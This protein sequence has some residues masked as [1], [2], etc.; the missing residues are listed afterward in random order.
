MA[1]QYYMRAFNTTTHNY[2]DWVV[3]DTPDSTGQFS[4]FP[5]NQLINITVNR[6]VQSKVHDFLKP[7]QSR[8]GTDGYFYHAN[9]Y[10]WIN[11]LAPLGPPTYLTGFMVERGLNP[12]TVANVF[13]ASNTTPI[14]ITTSGTSS[15]PLVNGQIVTI[16]GVT[17]NTNAN[18]TWPITVQDGTHFTLVGS[19]GSGAPN[20]NTGIVYYPQDA[21][22]IMWDEN[23]SLW[24]FVLN[25]HGDGV[26]LGASQNIKFNAALID[27][28]IALG[29]TPAL[30]GAIRLSNN[31]Y[32][33]GRDFLN[34][35]DVQMI[36]IDTFVTGTLSSRIKIGNLSTDVQ[37]NPGI[38][39]LDGYL[40]HT[41][42]GVDGTTIAQSGFIRDQNNTTIVAARNSTQ[43]VDLAAIGTTST[44]N[45]VV[46]D[47]NNATVQYNTA[48]GG[49][50]QFQVNSVPEAEIGLSF[51]RFP[52]G[53]VAPFIL[54]SSVSNTPAQTLTLQAQNVSSGTGTG[55]NL[56]LTSGAGS[57]SAN[58][59]INL[60][61]AGITR[62]SIN[63][64]TETYN[65]PNVTFASTVV[66]PNIT[67]A[68]TSLAA[69]QNLTI[70]AQNTS[71]AAAAGGALF[72]TSGSATAAA[73]AGY[74]HL[75]TGGVDQ[76]IVT[77]VNLPAKSF[78]TTSGKVTITGNLEV[79]GTL[80]TVDSTTVDIVG[81]VIHGNW[82]DPAV[83]FPV[84]VPVTVAGYAVHR[85]NVA[86]AQPRDA[87]NW[88]WTESTSSSTAS[89]NAVFGVST[90]NP[91]AGNLFNSDGYWRAISTPGDGFGIDGYTAFNS[92]ATLGI[93]GNNFIS[94]F[95]PNPA[96][97]TLPGTGSFKGTNN[98]T[99]VSARNLTASTTLVVSGT[100]PLALPQGTLNVVSTTGFT[101]PTGTLFVQSSTGTQTITYTNT[102]GTTFTGCVGGSGNI[103]TG[104]IVGQAV[105]TTTIAAG[106]NN[107][108][109]PTTT[110]NVTST[111]GFPQ[112]GTLR[113]ATYGGPTTPGVPGNG[114]GIVSVNYTS[115]VGN[116]FQGCTVATGSPT[117]GF[118]Y[119]GN[120]VQLASIAGNADLSLLG[121]DFG[122]HILHGGSAAVNTGQIFNTA[123]GGVYD[124]WV[125]GTSQVQLANADI[126][127]DGYAETIQVSPTVSNP[128]IYQIVQP[129]TGVNPGFNMLVQAQAGQQ[130]T[131][132][133]NNNNGGILTLASGAAGT[134]G[135]GTAAVAG[136]VTINVGSINN[137][138][139]NNIDTEADGY[140]E[141]LAIGP[142]L[143]NPRLYQ[144][145]LPGTG[146]G[147]GSAFSF[148]INAQGGQN[149]TSGTNN[150]GG[151]L[152]LASG[153][154]GTGGTGGTPGQI[155]L[156]Y[157]STLELTLTDGSLQ[158]SNLITNAPIISQAD[159]VTN[160]QTMT[161]QAQNGTSTGGILTL[162]SGTGA[163]TATAGNV[164]IET[165]GVDRI[166][167]YPT[168]S[169]VLP[170]G[171][172]N[173]PYTEFR[174][175]AQGVFIVPV[176]AGVSS[177]GFAQTATGAQIAQVALASGTG[178]NM[179]V[180]AQD[181]GTGTGG[182]LNLASGSGS[183]ANGVINFQPGATT[184]ILITA[185]GQFFQWVSTM[186]NPTINQATTGGASGTTLTVQAQNAA[187]TGGNLA[188]T[189]GTGTT[190]GNVNLQTGAAT[191]VSVNPTFTSFLD[192][193][194]AL[195]ITPVSA[196]T[197]HITFA[198]TDTAASIDQ[199]AT[200][201]ATGANMTVQAQNATTTGGNA[202]ITSGT[203]VTAGNVELQTGAVD[204]VVVHPT[205]TEFRDTAE[206]LRVTPVSAGT[207]QITF[208]STDTAAQINQTALASGTG[209]TM[210]VTA[211][212]AGTGTG[213]D[214]SLSSGS[215]TTA[216]GFVNLQAGGSTTARVHTNKFIFSKG[217]RR[218]ITSVTG[219]YGVLVTDD[220]IA[221]T[222]LAAPF[223]ISL[224]ASPTT[225]DEYLI[226]DTTGNAGASNVNIS[227]NGNNIDGAANFSLNAAYAAATF[228]FTGTQW[229]VS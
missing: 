92:F 111:V 157:G 189:S 198:S 181:A 197:T 147:G 37:Y 28:Y 162:T 208:A 44:N 148:K 69:G 176:S 220:Y 190:A 195:R 101:S 142:T 8:G 207:T 31:Q 71:A 25:T 174:D 60:Q 178:A 19:S 202:I 2:V 6:V 68:A 54:Q 107:V 47:A 26:T 51:I 99:A 86:Q 228:T 194:E 46:G 136:V 114:S 83:S 180:H 199:T 216:N 48:T 203:G 30:T 82:A 218:N 56:N 172:S 75:Q 141:W 145:T 224:P 35:A 5:S 42:L 206:A 103:S 217:R 137:S 214:L 22:T 140:A 139:F 223:T 4:G 168:G 74:I 125:N 10:D 131:G 84:S 193:A 121:T 126:D 164:K 133:A 61:T 158:W 81:A 80:T 135:G 166:I 55:G 33:T 122:N 123:T 153:I 151:N 39:Q 186:A 38:I 215:G 14:Q 156:F 78:P 110:I 222:T 210:T 20:T 32:I 94:S 49:I 113:I 221:I 160:G 117:G 171:P 90:T 41:A 129:Y 63:D 134:G 1:I 124:F 105:Q 9:A 187:T 229:S 173:V 201:G 106:S 179:T 163:T 227:G 169:P 96:L 170:L 108:Q 185:T 93:F 18:G 183:T 67:Q 184:Q 85:G 144:A 36:G 128:R 112:T 40:E 79:Q 154:P 196:G 200:A 192:T 118:L 64:T 225:G 104:G 102:T 175:T 16:I 152:A 204:R 213:G 11:A 72:F 24:R 65:I 50:H 15:P 167:T 87:A 98:T 182:N 21:S 29:S 116:Q 119:T 155:E 34:N 89:L 13:S 58:G 97:G 191:R 77:P 70:Q 209:A 73:N 3:N 91:T 57:G 59:V 100:T 146:T 226:K 138:T 205:F 45:L 43:L 161:M 150:N 76:L 188:L 130:Q 149:V 219:T 120:T 132:G 66:S 53:V 127:A 95:D 115:I 177:L 62:I 27:G 88:I 17:G 7:N 23:S 211:Q 143:V 159:G 52:A 109:L 212:G 12:T 165:G